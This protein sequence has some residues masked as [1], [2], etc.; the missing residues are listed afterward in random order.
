MYTKNT[1]LSKEKLHTQININEYKFK[2][3]KTGETSL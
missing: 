1:I 2:K 3:N